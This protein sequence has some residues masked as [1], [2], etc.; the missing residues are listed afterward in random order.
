M[1]RLLAELELRSVRM[2]VAE[3][4]GP[5][6]RLDRLLVDTLR[7]KGAVGSA[8]RVEHAPGPTEPLLWV[9]D[10]VCGAVVQ[11]RCGDGTYLRELGGAVQVILI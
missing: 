4:R 8:V 9:A 3:S 11:D 6:D 7:A 10:T 5:G 2:V 1:E